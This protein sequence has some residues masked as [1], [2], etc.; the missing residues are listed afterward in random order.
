SQAPLWGAGRDDSRIP[1]GDWTHQPPIP[2]WQLRRA[3][4]HCHGASSPRL[5]AASAFLSVSRGPV[6]RSRNQV[7]LEAKIISGIFLAALLGVIALWVVSKV[8]TI[9]LR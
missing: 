9:P 6:M 7:T 8:G 3:Q 4:R 5:H 2:L 1:R